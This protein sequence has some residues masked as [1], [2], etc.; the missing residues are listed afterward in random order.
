MT[1]SMFPNSSGRSILEVKTLVQI[2]S[3]AVVTVSVTQVQAQLSQM[4]RREKS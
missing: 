4:K 3:D 2:L 1:V